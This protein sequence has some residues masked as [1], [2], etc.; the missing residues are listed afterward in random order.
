MLLLVLY[1]TQSQQLLHLYLT[2][3]LLILLKE[4]T[5]TTQMLGQMQELLLL[6]LEILQK[7]LIYT[8]QMLEQ[9]LRS[10]RTA[11]N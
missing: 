9:E 4:L 5:F 2:T 7:D 3:I 10:L 1:H 6:I 11:H 8:S